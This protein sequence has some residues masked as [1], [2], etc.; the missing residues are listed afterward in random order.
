MTLARRLVLNRFG[1]PESLTD[2]Q[3]RRA[4]RLLLGRG[5]DVEHTYELLGGP[6]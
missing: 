2:P 6:E 3:R 5:F 4:F 1:Q